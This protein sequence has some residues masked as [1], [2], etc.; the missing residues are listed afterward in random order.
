MAF[1]PGWPVTILSYYATL[2]HFI[3]TSEYIPDSWAFCNFPLSYILGATG[4]ERLEHFSDHSILLTKSNDEELL[5]FKK[6][7]S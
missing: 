6:E 3:E 7:S 5:S 1:C 2:K 4:Q